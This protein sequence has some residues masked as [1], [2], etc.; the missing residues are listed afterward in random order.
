MSVVGTVQPLDRD[1]KVSVELSAEDLECCKLAYRA[2]VQKVGVSFAVFEA[3]KYCKVDCPLVNEC[4][5]VCSGL[6]LECSKGDV[7][8]KDQHRACVLAC[9]TD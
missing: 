2:F 9:P 5:S 7:T 8:C 6:K 3:E 1:E 4:L